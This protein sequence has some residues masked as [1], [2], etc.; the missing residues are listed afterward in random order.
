MPSQLDI[1]Y[2][3]Q[4]CD[5]DRNGR[6]S[7]P[8]WR[9]ICVMLCGIQPQLLG[10]EPQAWMQAP[11]QAMHMPMEAFM[12]PLPN[13]NTATNDNVYVDLDALKKKC[14]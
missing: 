1:M 13:A 9:R 4:L 14:N 7:L 8:E 11:M 3:L 10:I 5:S 12:H 2:I 6:I